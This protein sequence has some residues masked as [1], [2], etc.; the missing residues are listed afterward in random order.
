MS[1]KNSNDTIGNRN[2][3]FPACSTG[4]QL[5]TPR[6]CQVVMYTQFILWSVLFQPQKLYS[7]VS[8]DKINVVIGR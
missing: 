8:C 7:C 1:M 6:L 2:R 4:S 5:P 3:D